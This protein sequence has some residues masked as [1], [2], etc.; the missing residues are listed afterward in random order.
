MIGD[1]DLVESLLGFVF[2]N[3]APAYSG[4]NLADHV[5]AF[6]LSDDDK[7]VRVLPVVRRENEADVGNPTLCP[8]ILQPVTWSPG[9]NAEARRFR[10]RFQSYHRRADWFC[11]EG[12]LRGWVLR[13]VKRHGGWANANLFE[14]A[15]DLERLLGNSRSA[16]PRWNF[17][18]KR[19]FQHRR[20]LDVGGTRHSPVVYFL[21]AGECGRVKIGTSESIFDRFEHLQDLSPCRL[22]FLGTAE[23]GRDLETRIHG[24]LRQLRSHGEWFVWDPAI[25]R[26]VNQIMRDGTI[27]Q[28]AV[29]R[30]MDSG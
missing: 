18:R 16:D 2:D 22:K 4:N 17:T 8:A 29:N 14:R 19:F 15:A 28:L 3:P 13:Q 20:E 24:A 12:E 21:H 9:S 6:L 5:L 27:P 25:E 11:F 1:Y 7:F 30:L 26:A 23:G 10:K